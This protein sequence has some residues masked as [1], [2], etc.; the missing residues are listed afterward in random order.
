MASKSFDLKLLLAHFD[1]IGARRFGTTLPFE[2]IERKLKQI[3]DGKEEFSDKHIQAIQ[4]DCAFIRW[5]KFPEITQTEFE[6]LKGLF[7]EMR[8]RDEKLIW[9]VFDVFKNIEVAS[10]ILRFIDPR[11]YAIF[12]PPVENLLNIK[13]KHQVEKYL[14]YLEALEEIKEVYKFDSIAKVDMALWALAN[15]I[16]SESLKYDPVYRDIYERYIDTPNII[17]RIRA[18]NSLKQIWAEEPL[19]ID[20]ALLLMET[21]ATFAGIIAGRELECMIKAL[22]KRYRRKL[23]EKIMKGTRYLSVPELASE[24][25]MD[26]RI[27]IEDENKV[28]NWWDV[29]CKLIHDPFYKGKAE[30]ISDMIYGIKDFKTKYGV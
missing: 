14:N 30:Q 13:G 19:Y 22:C 4:E 12:S 29:R 24:L 26:K 21:D 6:Q 11:D 23:T 3:K 27:S 7:Q 28:K 15:L 16:N 25:V 2:H 1:D 18:R 10:C 9:R 5:W 8:P 20:L 17:K